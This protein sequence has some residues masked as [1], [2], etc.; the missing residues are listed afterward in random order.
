MRSLKQSF[1]FYP[2]PLRIEAGPM[3]VRPLPGLD[4]S[5]DAVL[6]GKHVEDGWVYAPPQEK[7]ELVSGQV[8]QLPYSSR[9]FGL[10][11]THAIQHSCPTGEDHLGFLLWTLSFFTGMRL[12]ACEAGFLDATPV[13]TGKK[14][15]DF[16]V[17][18]QGLA[19]A[20]ELAD[21][22]WR[23]HRDK[24]S[25]AQRFAAAVHALFVGQ[26]PQALQYERFIHLYAAI[27]SCHRLTSNLRGGKRCKQGRIEWTCCQLGVEAP[28]WAGLVASI[29][30]DTLHEALFIDEP[31][32]FAVHRSSPDRGIEL[33]IDFEMKNLVCRLLVALIGGSDPSYLSSPV[34]SRQNHGLSL[35]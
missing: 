7:S 32:G 6:G 13:R 30:N 16:V 33:P 22:F 10:P 25:Y 31:L 4:E 24:P 14:L 27:D 19:R 2:A 26:Y 20:L 29:R 35:S 17:K 15:V 18:D 1:G 5:V 8:R 12:T 11:R 28:E 23:K 21:S 34:C 9:V 3:S